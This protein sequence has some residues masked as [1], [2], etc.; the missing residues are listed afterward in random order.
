MQTSLFVRFFI[1]RFFAALGDQVLLF[2]VPLIIYAQTKSVALAGLA[3]FIEWLPRVLSLPV[4]GTLSDRFGGKVVYL[5][6]DIVRAIVG[7]SAFYLLLNF[8]DNTFVVLSVMMA[9]SAFF[10]AQSFI[11]MESMVPKLVD[12]ADLAKA[13]S[14]LQAIEQGTL[15]FGPMLGAAFIVYFD[16]FYLIAVAA[17]LFLLA[18]ATIATIKLPD[19]SNPAALKS[20]IFK[21]VKTDFIHA[22]GIIVARPNLVLLIV[23]S[24]SINLIIG[25]AIATA[26]MLST[27][28]FNIS[29]VEFGFQQSFAGAVT[30]VVLI[31]LPFIIN[32]VSVFTLGMLAYSVICMGA[33]FIG[34]SNEYWIYALCYALILA[35]GDVFNV[36]IRTERALVIP[37]EHLGKT[38]GLIVFL[39]QLTLPIAGIIVSTSA[40]ESGTKSLFWLLGLFTVGVIALSFKKLK[41]NS[42]MLLAQG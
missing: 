39:N 15:V 21:Q 9:I 17:G 25:T 40:T 29:S 8:A 2:A 22:W 31:G 42:Q 33:I 3:F 12:K 6:A 13:Q 36:Y 34:V 37:K 19:M 27:G 14:M 7:F 30:L 32:K 10:Y 16:A 4:A 5:T 20:N 35:S 41:S 26:A 24:V 18:F 11:A 28:Y 38:I 1:S 23:L